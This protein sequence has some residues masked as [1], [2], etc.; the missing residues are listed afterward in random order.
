[1]VQLL[2]GRRV[3]ADLQLPGALHVAP[4]RCL[5]PQTTR[6]P[7]LESVP[8]P[9]PR[10]EDPR[11]TNRAVPA[12]NGRGHSLPLPGQPNPHTMGE[13]CGMNLWRAGCV[14]TRSSG[15]EGGPGKR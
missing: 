11:R 10:M 13:Q 5:D 8:S 15:S 2:Q 1:M 7:E 6:Q 14:E 12:T 9:V 3:L 4:G